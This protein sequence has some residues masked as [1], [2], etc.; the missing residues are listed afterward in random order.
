MYF[1]HISQNMFGRDPVMYSMSFEILRE[2]KCREILQN[3]TLKIENV[4]KLLIKNLYE[5]GIFYG[6]TKLWILFASL[7]IELDK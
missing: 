2:K 1:Q 3:Y 6:E 5:R 4:R 7:S